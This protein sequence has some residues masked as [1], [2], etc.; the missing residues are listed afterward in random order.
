MEQK[1]RSKFL[2]WPGSN[3]GPWHLGAT[4]VATRLP[5]TPPFSRL[6]RH[7][8]GYSRTILTPSLQYFSKILGTD[9]WAFPQILEDRPPA[10]L[11]LR[12]WRNLT[13]TYIC[14]QCLPSRLP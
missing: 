10:P 13:M 11:S 14:Y 2:P 7:A 4:D 1:T 5:S 12:P 9:A 6:L 8:G 3:L